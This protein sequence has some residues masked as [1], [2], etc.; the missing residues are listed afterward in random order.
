[1]EPLAPLTQANA[2]NRGAT[3]RKKRRGEENTMG[4]EDGNATNSPAATHADESR[5]GSVAAKGNE[6]DEIRDAIAEAIHEIE[7]EV[8]RQEIRGEGG[9]G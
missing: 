7:T 9:E 3:K 8:V 6:M 5:E 4:D 1:M 2:K